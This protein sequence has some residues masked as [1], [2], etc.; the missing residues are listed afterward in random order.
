MSAP[1]ASRAVMQLA[2]DQWDALDRLSDLA[3][4]L[5]SPED[6][7]RV[8]APLRKGASECLDLIG[9][10]RSEAAED[11]SLSDEGSLVDEEEI[12]QVRDLRQKLKK[13]AAK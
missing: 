6:A 11:L 4:G 5:L 13:L 3:K 9:P 7:E 12:A 1:D 2:L 8:D 10:D